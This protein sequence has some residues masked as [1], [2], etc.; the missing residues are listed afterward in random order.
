MPKPG[1]GT[2]EYYEVALD[3]LACGLDPEKCTFLSSPGS[4]TDRANILLYESGYS[5]QSAEK[6]Y[7]KI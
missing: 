5:I 2:S 3:Y 7:C 6:S 4:G 1:E